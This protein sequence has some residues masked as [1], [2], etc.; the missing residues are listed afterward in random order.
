MLSALVD[1]SWLRTTPSG[2]YEMHEL[3]RQYAG[4]HLGED[5]EGADRM[6]N[7]HSRYYASFL[8]QR[9]RRA[10]REGKAGALQEILEDMDNVWSAWWRAVEQADV[11]TIGKSAM[12]LWFV[13]EAR[14]WYHETRQAC[15]SDIEQD[16]TL[17]RGAFCI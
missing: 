6:R 1:A 12:M 3:I 2:R 17:F 4:G 11:E 7:L 9:G 5:C 13:A 16:R 15:G 10:F 14:G 8:Q